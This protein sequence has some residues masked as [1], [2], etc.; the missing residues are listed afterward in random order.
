MRAVRPVEEGAEQEEEREYEEDLAQDLGPG[1]E[2]REGDGRHGEEP[3]RVGRGGDG[4]RLRAIGD[5]RLPNQKDVDEHNLTH[6]P[7]RNWCPHSV[8]GRGKD[9]DH[10][11]SLDED[12]RVRECSFDYCFPVASRATR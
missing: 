3:G 7:Y 9:L 6:V 8:R 4:A 1:E 12:R 11:R 5:P 2:E 10:R